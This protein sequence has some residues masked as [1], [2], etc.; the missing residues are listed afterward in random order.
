MNRL[1]NVVLNSK[2]S[3]DLG[4]HPHKA[5]SCRIRMVGPSTSALHRILL[6]EKAHRDD[7]EKRHKQLQLL[8]NKL[9]EDCDRGKQEQRELLAFVGK[10]Q[11]SCADNSKMLSTLDQAVQDLAVARQELAVSVKAAAENGIKADR[12][13]KLNSSLTAELHAKALQ[14]E[15]DMTA[16]KKAAED[17]IGRLQQGL[18]IEKKESKATMDQMRTQHEKQACTAFC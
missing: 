11:D 6:H 4:H 13:R 15:R 1:I 12:L 7:L 5:S 3:F 9:Q 8:C 17:Q 16:T 10:F 2:N 18:S 14:S